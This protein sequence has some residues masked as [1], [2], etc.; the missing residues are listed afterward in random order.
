M[1]LSVFSGAGGL[2]LGFEKAGFDIGLAFDLRP[3]SIASYNANRP[4]KAVGH[5]ADVRELDLAQLDAFYG[6]AFAP[7]GVIGGPPCQSFSRANVVSTSDDPRHDLPITYANLILRINDR[8]PISFFVFEN[9][10]GLL[11]D[12]HIRKY[13]LLKE[14]L[15]SEFDLHEALLNSKDYNTPQRRVRIF[16]IGINRN[17]HPGAVWK[18]PI[19]STPFGTVLTVRSAIGGL[20]EPVQYRAG[21][22]ASQIPFHQNHW[23]MKPK[24][25]RFDGRLKPGDGRK[26]SFKTLAWDEPSITVAYGN[27]EVHVHPSCQR[28]LSVYEAMLLQGFPNNY[29]LLG[30]LSSQI[31]QV[32]EAV[33]PP[34]AHAVA[35]SVRDALSPAIASSSDAKPP[36]IRVG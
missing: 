16:L 19:E 6:D 10:T 31:T 15:R 3:D 36:S 18:R 1:L 11:S 32:S 5:V 35:I 29:K 33:P 8:S 23:C 21:L 25:E 4:G 28:R 7:E 20:P 27:R 13:E 12:K 26:R 22:D 2:D 9:V 14:T 34:L 17:K 30:S 24:S